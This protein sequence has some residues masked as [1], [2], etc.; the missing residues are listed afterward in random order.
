MDGTVLREARSS[1]SSPLSASSLAPSMLNPPQLLISGVYR[2]SF[3]LL[4]LVKK[5]RLVCTEGLF[6]GV[7]GSRVNFHT[8]S[9]GCMHVVSVERL[10]SIL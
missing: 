2:E 5:L 6:I 4:P 10:R 3:R 9:N 7:E 1:S 8:F